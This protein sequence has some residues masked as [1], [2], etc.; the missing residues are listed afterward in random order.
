MC[1]WMNVTRNVLW[2]SDSKTQ[3]G[4]QMATLAAY[5]G[6]GQQK[7]RSLDDVRMNFEVLKNC[8]TVLF[9]ESSLP[10]VLGSNS[11]PQGFTTVTTRSSSLRSSYG[12]EETNRK[13]PPI[14]IVHQRRVPYAN[15]RFG[16]VLSL[17]FLYLDYIFT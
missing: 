17:F 1:S 13:S 7:H 14:P 2:S 5:F 11:K 10:D 9:L 15:G 12:G 16:K 6:L 4:F 8:A 3:Q